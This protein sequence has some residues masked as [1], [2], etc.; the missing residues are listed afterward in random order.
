MEKETLP[1]LLPMSTSPGSLTGSESAR[2]GLYTRGFG[3]LGVTT[4]DQALLVLIFLST[5]F[6]TD[7]AG[8]LVYTGLS[9][10]H[11]SPL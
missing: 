5:P 3:V 4:L 8:D 1:L 6:K 9:R 7:E 11:L 2:I 10:E